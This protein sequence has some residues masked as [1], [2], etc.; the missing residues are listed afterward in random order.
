MSTLLGEPI[1]HS[2]GARILNVNGVFVTS[3]DFSRC[4]FVRVCVRLCVCRVCVC[5]YV[6][7][8]V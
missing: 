7:I 8:C 3:K 6:Y 5:V 1:I 4:V 2:A